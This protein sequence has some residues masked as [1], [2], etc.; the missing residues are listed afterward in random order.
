MLAT[1]QRTRFVL[2]GGSADLYTG[3]PQGQCYLLEELLDLEIDNGIRKKLIA[4]SMLCEEK[5]IVRL[6]DIETFYG[7]ADEERTEECS[8]D[9][10]ISELYRKRL[11][12]LQRLDRV[13]KK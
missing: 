2:W 3:M 11:R 7:K 10:D 4:K 6:E 8:D 12:Q 9:A 5:L 1:G 13:T